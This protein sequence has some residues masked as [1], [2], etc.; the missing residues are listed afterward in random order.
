MRARTAPVAQEDAAQPQED[1]NQGPRPRS[2]SPRT[3]AWV[4]AE[5]KHMEAGT[6]EGGGWLGQLSERLK[7]Q[8]KEKPQPKKQA[9]KRQEAVKPLQGSPAGSGRSNAP[10][11]HKTTEGQPSP[12]AGG[13]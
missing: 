7:G 8:L 11:S 6:K 13:K 12:K 10:K 3:L 1:P 4:G 5:G 9:Q 2:R